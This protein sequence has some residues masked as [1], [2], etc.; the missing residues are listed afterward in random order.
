[1]TSSAWFASAVS[2]TDPDL[3]LFCLHH[4]GGGA[5]AY[6]E[7]QGLV[8]DRIEIVPVQLPGREARFVEPAERSIRQLSRRLVEPVLERAAAGPFALFGHS[9]GALLAYDLS[10]ALQ[11][12]GRPPAHL[13]VSAHTPPHV[14]D[15]RTTH[16]L[17]DKEF[18]AH[19][20]ELGGTSAGVLDPA[21][22]ELV[23]PTLRADFTA[24]ETYEHEDGPPL[25]MPV[26]VFGGDRDPSVESARLSRWAE[27]TTAVTTVELFPGGHFYLLEHRADV[28]RSLRRALGVTARD[29]SAL[30][31]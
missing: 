19:V 13:V 22:L 11:R 31:G 29:P 6:R 27:L 16:T 10:R 14:L 15:R 7:W 18:L 5:S 28:V 26:T 2:R 20:L 1:M 12:A 3:R 30:G 9:M 24:C 8:G 21:L 25:T 4:A 23:L 17:P